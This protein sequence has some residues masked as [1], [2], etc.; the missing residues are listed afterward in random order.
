MAS[1]T[2]VP[3]RQNGGFLAEIG[4]GIDITAAILTPRPDAQLTV[5]RFPTVSPPT[6]RAPA[7]GPQAYDAIAASVAVAVNS[8]ETLSRSLYETAQRFRE[9]QVQGANLDLVRVATG[10]RL[11]TTLADASASAAGLDL[12]NLGSSGRLDAMGQA[13]DELTSFQFAEDWNGVADA[14]E[15]RVLPALSGWR[16]IFTEILVH[17]DGRFRQPHAS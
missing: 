14:L 17:A 15:H 16:E 10:L 11:L 13:L 12:S 3:Q 6:P 4:P 9:G 1:A 5:S 8:L 7:R 2:M